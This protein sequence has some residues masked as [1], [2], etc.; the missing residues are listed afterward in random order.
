MVQVD[1]ETQI[2]ENEE[3]C[4]EEKAVGMNRPSLTETIC[5]KEDTIF[6]DKSIETTKVILVDTVT[7]MSDAED[8]ITEEQAVQATGMV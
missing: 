1:A 4:F 2:I 7:E 3:V 8:V 6:E 5:E